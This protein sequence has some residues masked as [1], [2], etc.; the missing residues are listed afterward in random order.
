MSETEKNTSKT[1]INTLAVWLSLVLLFGF[2]Q[3]SGCKSCTK[4][5]FVELTRN[6]T[7]K[8]QRYFARLDYED[9]YCNYSSIP[10]PVDEVNE[11]EAF[12]KGNYVKAE[13]DYAGRL[14]KLVSVASGFKL[15]CRPFLDE[16]GI[17]GHR[18][19][20]LKEPLNREPIL[21]VQYYY[22]SNENLRRIVKKHT[23]Y[24]ETQHSSEKTFDPNG[25]LIE[26]KY[27]REKE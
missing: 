17:M 10:I 12:Q 15:F 8:P 26:S 20:S 9:I 23:L 2:V 7:S 18:T 22:D 25:K 24:G 6:T 21:H 27:L 19:Y 5:D 1:I 4:R 3:I 13:Y 14:N 11:S 16:S